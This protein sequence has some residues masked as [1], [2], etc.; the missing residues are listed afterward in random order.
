MFWR[1]ALCVAD[2]AHNAMCIRFGLCHGATFA[3]TC[4]MQA[5]IFR[6]SL[7]DKV[8]R[9]DWRDVHPHRGL[10]GEHRFDRRSWLRFERLKE[11]RISQRS[12]ASACGPVHQKRYLQENETA[13]LVECLLFCE[14]R[15]YGDSLWVSLL[16]QR[17]VGRMMFL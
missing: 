11:V 9:S 1:D 13:V 16:F 7:V 5:Y 17:Y 14:L 10:L 15:A 3:S 12:C 6:P 4:L 8:K 2:L